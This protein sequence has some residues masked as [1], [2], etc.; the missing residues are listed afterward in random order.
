MKVNMFSQ[1]LQKID[2]LFT[3]KLLAMDELW[4]QIKRFL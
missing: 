2:G 3:L 1:S 4:Y